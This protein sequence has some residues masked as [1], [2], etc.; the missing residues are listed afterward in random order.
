MFDTPIINN[1]VISFVMLQLRF[2]NEKE[3]RPL[4]SINQ[5][6]SVDDLFKTRNRRRKLNVLKVTLDLA[7]PKCFNL[8][9]SGAAGIFL[10]VFYLRSFAGAK[11]VL[12]W[13]LCRITN[14]RRALL[15]LCVCPRI[16]SRPT[17]RPAESQEAHSDMKH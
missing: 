11:A 8:Y 6:S 10:C 3:C 9:I 15:L 5:K 1:A 13:L 2:I 7:L 12:K 16:F 14:D 17:D 4:V